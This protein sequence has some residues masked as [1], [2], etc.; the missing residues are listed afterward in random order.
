MEDQLA[1]ESALDADLRLPVVIDI[2][3]SGFGQGSYPIEVGLALQDGSTHCF[4]IQPLS[5]WSHWSQE[6]EDIH[7][8]AHDTL[9]RHGKPARWVAEQLNR[10][11]AGQ[12]AYTDAWGNDNSW[13]G[14]LYEEVGLGQRY[15]LETIRRLL[16]ET[17]AAAW[18][19][20]REALRW[21]LKAR[22]HRASSD[23]LVLQRTYQELCAP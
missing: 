16:S 11:L 21:R 9:L 14:R 1:D 10:L 8:I 22:R 20:T 18:S 6:A 12:T 2:E 17:Q 19:E 3:A 5:H 4:L 15:R 23:A 13:L 7:G